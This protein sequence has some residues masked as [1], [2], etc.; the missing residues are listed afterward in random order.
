ML[1]KLRI[2]FIETISSHRMGPYRKHGSLLS[3]CPTA[4][5]PESIKSEYIARVTVI[6]ADLVQ[7]RKSGLRSLSP[8]V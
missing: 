6:T 5:V 7:K 2:A 3:V 8:Q 1:D 4:S